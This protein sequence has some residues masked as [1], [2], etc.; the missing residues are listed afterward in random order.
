M[1]YIALI[2][3]TKTDNLKM[4]V[5]LSAVL[6]F[7]SCNKK[8]SCSGYQYVIIA[9]K[10]TDTV[11]NTINLLDGSLYSYNPAYAYNVANYYMRN[12]YNVIVDS[13]IIGW[14]QPII[15]QGEV[16]A[17]EDNGLKCSQ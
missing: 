15:D 7:I 17:L 14:A 2:T 16:N 5:V 4:D 9:T 8:W 3:K 6:C 13:T 1:K 10:G 12:G 11:T